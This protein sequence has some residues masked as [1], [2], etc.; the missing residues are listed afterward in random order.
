MKSALG[1][2][3]LSA[4]QSTVPDVAS[5]IACRK[6]GGESFGVRS[7]QYAP[8][9]QPARR[10]SS[11]SRKLKYAADVRLARGE[12]DRV[13]R[14]RPLVGRGRSS[15]PARERRARRPRRRA[16]CARSPSRCTWL[17][18]SGST[19]VCDAGLRVPDAHALL[20]R[21]RLRRAVER[22]EEVVHQLVPVAERDRLRRDVLPPRAL[23]CVEAVRVVADGVEERRRAAARAV[24]IADGRG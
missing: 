11:A 8:D 3:P 2:P 6:A 1:R 14:L 17:A 15:R 22:E 18:L 10:G 7:A 4:S 21:D 19:A 13:E 24:R 5:E 9:C 23:G 16:R 12:P 20:A